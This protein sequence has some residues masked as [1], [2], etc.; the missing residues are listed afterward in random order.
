MSFADRGNPFLP[1]P[2]RHPSPVTPPGRRGRPSFA[3]RVAG[4][5]L[6]A[7]ALVIAAVA[8]PPADSAS[9]D[10]AP[11][12]TDA[13]NAAAPEDPELPAIHAVGFA[14]SPDAERALVRAHLAEVEAALRA[15]PTDHLDAGK[16][17]N[18]ATLLDELR[19]YRL[20][21]I[22]PRNVDVPGRSPVFV[23]NDG[24][25]CAVGYLIHRSG[26]DE[27]VAAV[28]GARNHARIFELLDEPAL[29]AWLE[30][31]GLS[32]VEAAWI[33]P[34]YCNME[35]D[36][37]HQPPWC[38]LWPNPGREEL[39]REYLGLTVGTSTL[40]AALAAVNLLD[41][42][43]GQPSAGRGLLGMGVGA[44]GVGLG[45]AGILDGGDARRAGWVNVAFGVLGV[46]SG[47]WTFH[48][49][50]GQE[51]AGSGGQPILADMASGPTLSVNPWVPS[52]RAGANPEAVGLRIRIMHECRGGPGALNRPHRAPIRPQ[53]VRYGRSLC[54]TAA[55]CAIRPR[56]ALIL[57][58][59]VS[60][61][62]QWQKAG[63][64]R[65]CFCH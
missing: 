19:A 42:S 18:R 11:D 31:S 10:D 64:F 16:R 36:A 52:G 37:A 13:A 30:G 41:L 8:L 3:F 9:P 63:A 2:P 22:F 15:A 27:L 14:P 57:P 20:A 35:G 32:P 28:A 33:Q 21:G 62:L 38:N 65:G 56:P 55:A 61:E 48:R 43:A 12:V 26:G 29:V 45:A 47:A 4:A 5:S 53:P 6:L 59:E 7:T 60:P 49:A 58:F 17:A 39:S 46:G 23:D 1:E 54:D 34:M 40:G 25:H 51:M 44:A 50:R 24:V